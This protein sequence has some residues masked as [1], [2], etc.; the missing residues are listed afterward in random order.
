MLSHSFEVTKLPEL[1]SE[2]PLYQAA[3]LCSIHSNYFLR[4]A[5]IAVCLLYIFEFVCNKLQVRRRKVTERKYKE[6]RNLQKDNCM[7]ELR[8]PLGLVLLGWP[9]D[10]PFAN[11]ITYRLEEKKLLFMM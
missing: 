5:S 4:R 6:T 10:V 3:S 2:S 8:N 1:V 11:T 7:V 9:T